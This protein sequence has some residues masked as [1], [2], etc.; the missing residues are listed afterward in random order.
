MFNKIPQ[1]VFG[2]HLTT[3][4]IYGQIRL[5]IVIIGNQSRHILGII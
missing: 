4:I 3:D 1:G 5:D 2:F